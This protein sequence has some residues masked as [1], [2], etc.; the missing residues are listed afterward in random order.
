MR[1]LISLIKAF[2]ISGWKINLKSEIN[3]NKI[4]WQ[5]Y[6]GKGS[7]GYPTYSD[8]REIVL[9]SYFFLGGGGE[10]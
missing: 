10:G 9:I 5:V 6:L 4:W 1:L 2:N 7:L 3:G 8:I